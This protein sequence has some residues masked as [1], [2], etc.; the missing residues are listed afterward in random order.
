M[1]GDQINWRSSEKLARIHL[2][3]TE[4]AKQHVINQNHR[5]HMKEGKIIQGTKCWDEQQKQIFQSGTS[6]YCESIKHEAVQRIEIS[7]RRQK[8]SISFA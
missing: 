7:V 5:L 6:F 3:L 4:E 1:V 8:S 2:R